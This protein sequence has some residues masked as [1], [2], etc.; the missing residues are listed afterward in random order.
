M[1]A[2]L[3]AS[4]PKLR[5]DELVVLPQVPE[6]PARDT[7]DLI[8]QV[9]RPEPKPQP[10]PEPEPEPEAEDDVDTPAEGVP[11][12]PVAPEDLPTEAGM[13][14]FDDDEDEVEWFKA[15]STP[16]PPP[17][18]F[19]EPPERPLFAP[20]PEDGGPVRRSR[21]PPTRRRAGCRRTARS[22][23]RG[24]PAPAAAPGRA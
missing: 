12:T 8:P 10:P 3:V 1:Q 6:I 9:R 5:P 16:A 21:V 2:A 17:P 11:A 14:I 23:G 13:P 20:E 22:T 19:E 7:S 4:I 15:R 24:R 18:P